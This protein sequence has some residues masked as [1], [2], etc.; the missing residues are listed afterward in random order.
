MAKWK[1]TLAM[2]IARR[3]RPG[4]RVTEVTPSSDGRTWY[5]MGTC[6]GLYAVE[7]I[8]AWDLVRETGARD[9]DAGGVARA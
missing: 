6:H 5:V 4:L 9:A 3:R 2:R 8:D 7:R 1:H